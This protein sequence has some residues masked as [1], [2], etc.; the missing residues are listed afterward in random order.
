MAAAT[1]QVPRWV[2]VVVLLVCVVGMLL[3]ARGAEHH[4]GTQEGALSAG[5]AVSQVLGA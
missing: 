4:R 2:L 1:A 3:W 5:H